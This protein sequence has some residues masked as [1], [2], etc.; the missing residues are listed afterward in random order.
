MI[1]LVGEVQSQMYYILG[2]DICLF[3]NVTVWDPSHN[4][5]HYMVLGCLCRVTLRKNAKYFGRLVWIPL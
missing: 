3:C 4:S 5:D 2:T 1:R